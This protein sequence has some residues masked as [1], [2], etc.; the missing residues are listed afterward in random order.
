MQTLTDKRRKGR[1]DVW[2]ITR[3]VER[4]TVDSVFRYY[5]A[6]ILFVDGPVA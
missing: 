4:V 5:V 1:C 2:Y 6:T 3:G